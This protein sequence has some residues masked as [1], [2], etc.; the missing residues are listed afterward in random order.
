MLGF[1]ARS[2]AVGKGNRRQGRLVRYR[3][4][5]RLRHTR[6]MMIK[7][8]TGDWGLAWDSV[9]RTVMFFVGH[10]YGFTDPSSHLR[11]GSG[12]FFIFFITRGLTFGLI[13]YNKRTD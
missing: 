4:K 3:R 10:I 5:A 8:G 6:L 12:A 11:T 7:V 9:R 1:W 2:G 13:L